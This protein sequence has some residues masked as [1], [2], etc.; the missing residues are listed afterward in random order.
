MSSSKSQLEAEL[1]A[2]FS[3]VGQTTAQEKGQKMAQAIDKYVEDVVDKLS[4]TG[5]TH[6]HSTSAPG[7]PTGPAPAVISP[8]GIVVG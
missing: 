4:A 8:G 7:A 6:T 2:I 1:I 3:E 5:D